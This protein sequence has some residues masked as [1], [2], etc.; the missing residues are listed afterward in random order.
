M[1]NK[2]SFW[3]TW[4]EG[5]KEGR[6]EGKGTFF[7]LLHELENWWSNLSFILNYFEFCNHFGSFLCAPH[8]YKIR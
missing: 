3:D 5:R 4:G 6:K 2:F 8:I 7:F 1:E